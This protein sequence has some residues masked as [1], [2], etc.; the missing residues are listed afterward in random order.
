MNMALAQTLYGGG[1]GSGCT[2]PNCGRPKE[3]SPLMTMLEQSSK[4]FGGTNLWSKLAK[5]GHVGNLEPFTTEELQ[6]LKRLKGQIGD[7]K[8]GMCYMNS[9]HLA[10]AGLH[11]NKV[12][13]VEGLMSLHGIPIDHSWIEYN[14]KV[15]DP[16]LASYK[17]GKPADYTKNNSRQ[18]MKAIPTPEYVGVVVP[19]D[20]IFNHQLKLGTYSP[21]THSW[22]DTKLQEKIWK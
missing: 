12:Q 8:V 4:V 16:T 21:L 20:E 19:K 10:L 14:G 5:Y 6:T 11:D 17:A 9:Q 15:Y 18:L 7:C 1:P 22:R 13:L 2:G 3:A